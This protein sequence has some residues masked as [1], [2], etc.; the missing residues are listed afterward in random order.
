[1]R[2][3]NGLSRLIREAFRVGQ[4]PQTDSSIK[5]QMLTRNISTLASRFPTPFTNRLP[6]LSH[7]HLLPFI[8]RFP[9]HFLRNDQKKIRSFSVDRVKVRTSKR[10][11]L[12]TKIQT[13]TL[14]GKLNI[15]LTQPT[16]DDLITRIRF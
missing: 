7:S 5:L 14:T 8:S 16:D 6:L 10:L 13:K 11:K 15:N 4:S 2:V 3:I 9:F 1:M 12:F